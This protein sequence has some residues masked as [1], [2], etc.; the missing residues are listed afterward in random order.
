MQFILMRNKSLQTLDLSE[1]ST[2]QPENLELVFQKFDQV[3][4]V[5]TLIAENLNTDFNYISDMFGDALAYNTKMEGLSL[6][7]NKIK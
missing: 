4:S 1:C 3:C 6:K 2:D 7:E 5:R